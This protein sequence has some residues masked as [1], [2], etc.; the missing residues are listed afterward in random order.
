VLI[1]VLSFTVSVS[2]T[3]LFF[4]YGFN[5]YYLLNASRR[6][7]LPKVKM[8]LENIPSVCIHLPI[9]NEKY[10]VRRLVNACA[11]MAQHYDRSK[12]RILVLDDSTDDTYDEVRKIATEYAGKGFNIEI[13]H[14]KNRQGFKA[15]ALEA[16]LEKTPEEFVAIFDADFIPEQDFLNR[17]IPYFIQDK[18]LGIVQSRWCHLNRDYNMLTFAVAISIDIHFIIEQTGRYA[19]GLF[20]NFNGS[21]GVLR[22]K[23]IE[24]AGGWQ[25]DTL[26][27][28]LDLSYRIQLK[29]YRML[30]V[31]DLDSPAELPPTVPSYKQQQGRWANGS[32]RTAKKILPTI[33]QNDDLPFKQ[34]LQ[35]FIHLTGY[36]IHPLMTISF[37]VACIE[38]L[39]NLNNLDAFQL[40]IFSQVQG[41]I[42]FGRA[43]EIL[44]FERSTWIILGPFILLCTI[45]PWISTLYILKGQKYS[46][47]HNMAGFVVL[48]LLGFG[49]SLSNTF[50]IAKGLL[51][52]RTWEFSRTPKYANL[53]DKSGWQTKKYQTP[54]NPLWMFECVFASLGLVT[55][56][57]AIA[58]SNFSALF[59]LVPFTSAYCFIFFQTI[60][61]TQGRKVRSTQHI[62]V[63]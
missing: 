20:Q 35:A 33:V 57:F 29:G 48:F 55:I 37:I 62:H 28:D 26:T 58:H 63:N 23:A 44:S 3:I 2:L 41:L 24:D 46:F 47:L 31:K 27:E 1:Q 9:Y 8:P 15:G 14:R 61:Q 60:R 59:I 19:L 6:Y 52:N 11:D 25:S 50:E 10:V 54:F 43:L 39:A 13:L 5:H 17:T 30:Y 40:Y 18:K 53:Q 51:T 38:T 42:S 12:V 4:I 7:H 56:A 32:L 45:G 22:K 36:L 34:R 49:L 16:A 21:G